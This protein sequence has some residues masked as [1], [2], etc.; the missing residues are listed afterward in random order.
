MCT[1]QLLN[2][3]LFFFLLDARACALRPLLVYEKGRFIPSAR[4][5]GSEAGTHPARATQGPHAVSFRTNVRP[6]APH[7][8]HL[9]RLLLL[10]AHLVLPRDRC[11]LVLELDPE[12]Q[13]DDEE[14]GRERPRHHAADRV[15]HPPRRDGTAELVLE[16]PATV[17]RDD[18]LCAPRPCD[19]QR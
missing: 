18:V 5:P 15:R 1:G 12:R 6:S 19:G 9:L 8:T 3:F 7:V 2:L 4:L 13:D 10:R 17:D 11:L 14:G 16:L